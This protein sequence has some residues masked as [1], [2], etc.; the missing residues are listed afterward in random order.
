MGAGVWGTPP[1]FAVAGPVL[2]ANRANG[3]AKQGGSQ[4]PRECALA[5]AQRRTGSSAASRDSLRRRPRRACMHLLRQQQVAVP[6]E[7]EPSACSPPPLLSRAPRAHSRL[8]RSERLA[9]TARISPA[10]LV[11]IKPIARSRT[12]C[13]LARVSDGLPA[14][15]EPGEFPLLGQA[16]FSD[17]SLMTFRADSFSRAPVSSRFCSSSL[18]FC[19]LFLTYSSVGHRFRSFN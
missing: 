5:S 14:S 15:R 8:D 9:R 19:S 6:R 17:E 4:R 16:C 2:C 11:S 1:A 18:R 12:P 3:W 10:H 7:R 13:A